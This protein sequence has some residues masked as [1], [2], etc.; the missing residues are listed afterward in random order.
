MSHPSA[1]IPAPDPALLRARP[2]TVYLELTSRCNAQCVYCSVSQPGY[3]A[4]DLELDFEAVADL[5]QRYHPGEVRLSGNGETTVL[6]DWTRAVRV[7]LDRG[8]PVTLTTNLAKRFS[9][10]EI[11]VLTRFRSL[12][13]SCDSADAGLLAELRRG[14]W[15]EVV[16]ENLA[17]VLKAAREGY[18]DPPYLN[19]S[20]TLTDVAVPGLPDLVRWA[21]AQGAHAVGLVNVECYPVPPGAI[22]F[23]HPAEADPE[24]ARARISQAR[25]L[26]ADLGL[27][28]TIEPGLSDALK[29]AEQ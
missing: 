28:L 29:G 27:N 25:E 12:E 1:S 4:R 10:E 23:R 14:V 20:C 16:E 2:R 3:E 5:L 21:A 11:E 24:E 6:P 18:R 7:L 8:F 15:L 9:E 19:I 26:A 17:R 13:I 22:R